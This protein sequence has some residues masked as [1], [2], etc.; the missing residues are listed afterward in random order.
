MEVLEGF[1]LTWSHVA[2]GAL[3]CLV[4]FTGSAAVLVSVLVKLPAGYFRGPHPPPF[5][6]GRHPVLRVVGFIAKN[7]LGVLLI[8]LGIFLSVPGMLGQGLLTIFIGIMLLNFPRK[9]RLEQRLV[10]RPKVFGAIN[11]I[12]N[13]F[14]KPPLLLDGDAPYAIAGQ[15]DSRRLGCSRPLE[16]KAREVV[17]E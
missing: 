3:F 10:S 14:G 16:E 12:R 8:M 7:L 1:E 13:R 11:W 2:W 6:A 5:W 4:S 15:R 17:I 9:R